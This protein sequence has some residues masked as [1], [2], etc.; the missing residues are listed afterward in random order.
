MKKFKRI[1]FTP[2]N[3]QGVMTYQMYKE[4][5]DIVDV[6]RKCVDIYNMDLDG[7][8]LTIGLE[9]DD[10]SFEVNHGNR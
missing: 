5:A 9:L 7:Y 8:S 3:P 2:P 10:E 6:L 1:R 4:G